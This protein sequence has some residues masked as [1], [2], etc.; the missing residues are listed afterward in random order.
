MRG[1][2]WQER[3]KQVLGWSRAGSRAERQLQRKYTATSFDDMGQPTQINYGNAETP[4][5]EAKV[6][7]MGHTVA[8]HPKEDLGARATVKTVNIRK[9]LDPLFQLILLRT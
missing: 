3:G 9:I 1:S 6:P 7:A 5:P 8:Q 2:V 4:I